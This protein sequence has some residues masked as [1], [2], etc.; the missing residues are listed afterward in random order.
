MEENKAGPAGQLVTID[1]AQD[2]VISGF[3]VR[4]VLYVRLA[5][6]TYSIRIGSGHTHGWCLWVVW[7]GAPPC[8]YGSCVP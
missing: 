5:S 1:L 2:N 3:G 6:L 8:A 7:R 4:V